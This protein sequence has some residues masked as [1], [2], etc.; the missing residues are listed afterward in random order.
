MEVSRAP[1]VFPSFLLSLFFPRKLTVL[2]NIPRNPEC[3]FISRRS[4]LRYVSMTGKVG[5]FW[6]RVLGEL[7]EIY[8]FHRAS[9]TLLLC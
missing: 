5:D 6:V 8:D 2:V 3:S 7:L 9:Y 4:S 1:L